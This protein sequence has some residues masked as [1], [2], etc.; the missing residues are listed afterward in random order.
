MQDR[1][2]TVEMLGGYALLTHEIYSF[3][4]RGCT[5]FLTT[6]APVRI[7]ISFRFVYHRHEVCFG[8]FEMLMNEKLA[9][10]IPGQ[11]TAKTISSRL[12][13]LTPPSTYTAFP[14]SGRRI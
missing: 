1:R 14:Q 12:K 8:L 2:G 10:I 7:F 3:M 5:V 4:E 6:I 13:A 11:R 9:A